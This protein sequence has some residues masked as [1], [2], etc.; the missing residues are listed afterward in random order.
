MHDQGKVKENEHE[1]DNGEMPNC[2]GEQN[3]ISIIDRD[4]GAK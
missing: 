3:N 1:G 4:I 2:Q